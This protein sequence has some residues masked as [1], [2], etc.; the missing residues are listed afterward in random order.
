MSKASK[1]PLEAV[2]G[3]YTPFPHAVLDSLAFMGA[4]DRAKAMLCELMRQHNTRNNGHLHLAV[5]WLRKRGWKSTSAIQLA[6]AELVA[7]GLAML[8]S[9][10]GLNAGPDRYALTWLPICDH[11]GL[12][13]VTPSTYAPGAWRFADPPPVL[14]NRK[15]PPPDNRKKRDERTDSRNSTVPVDGTA[16]PPTVPAA[17]TK[18]PVFGCS[19]VP[20][21]GNNEVTSSPAFNPFIRKGWGFIGWHESRP[22]AMVSIFRH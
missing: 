6:K 17:G 4:S 19:T 11:T 8:T 7:R 10:G 1:K 9:R 18:T 15:A 16:S 3:S 20:A 22:P 12:S 2:S 5:G 21:V 13:E 14:S